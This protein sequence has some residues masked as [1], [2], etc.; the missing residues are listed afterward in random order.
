MGISPTMGP[1]RSFLPHLEGSEV[2]GMAG[3]AFIYGYRVC[4]ADGA[5]GD[6]QGWMETFV[7]WQRLSCAH[8][9]SHS[10]RLQLCPAPSWASHPRSPSYPCSSS[11][12]RSWGDL[13]PSPSRAMEGLTGIHVSPAGVERGGRRGRES[14]GF[15]PFSRC[16]LLI[17]WRGR[18]GRG[19]VLLVPLPLGAGGFAV[20]GELHGK[21]E[22]R[23]T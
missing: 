4:S 18:G 6:S 21:G 1:G 12:L 10:S 17:G 13:C 11:P 15:H 3:M 5:D 9:G 8:G 23:E 16:R 7:P 14:P 2:S 19:I 20:H 22:E